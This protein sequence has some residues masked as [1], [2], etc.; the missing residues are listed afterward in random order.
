[1]LGT[2]ITGKVI[3]TGLSS[4]TASS[5]GHAKMY[6]HFWDAAVLWVLVLARHAFAPTC[7]SLLVVTPAAMLG[8]LGF[9]VGTKPGPL[10]GVRVAW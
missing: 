2:P 5:Y 1:M 4:A 8:E 10:F 6:C 9:F 3:T 7:A